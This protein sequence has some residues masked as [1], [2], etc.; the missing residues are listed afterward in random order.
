MLEVN[1]LLVCGLHVW[2]KLEKIDSSGAKVDGS[3]GL[4]QMDGWDDAL[5]LS[6]LIRIHAI[7]RKEG[8]KLE[9]GIQE[10]C[11]TMLL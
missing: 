1:G 10:W 5:C 11:Q 2:R 3:D 4:I 6:L 8:N 9:T 7:R